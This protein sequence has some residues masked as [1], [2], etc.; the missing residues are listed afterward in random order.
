MKR[1]IEKMNNENLKGFL[2]LGSVVL[3]EGGEKRL[4]IVGRKQIQETSRQSYDYSAVLF[5][6]GYQNANQLYLFNAEDISY[7]FQMGLLDSEELAFQNL[8]S[9]QTRNHNTIYLEAKKK[10][11]NAIQSIK[12][13]NDT[14]ESEWQG[15]LFKSYLETY[16]QLDEKMTDFIQLLGKGDTLLQEYEQENGT[17][18]I[19]HA[20]LHQVKQLVGATEAKEKMKELEKSGA[21][22]IARIDESSFILA[23]KENSEV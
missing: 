3:L 17:T 6:E 11:E 20:S 21:A 4:M 1:K 5:P 10:I 19:V 12:E 2:P 15:Q 13:M 7:I 22:T 9:E 16:Q 18:N 23:N 14:V 8:L